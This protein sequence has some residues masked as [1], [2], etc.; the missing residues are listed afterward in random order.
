MNI[1]KPKF[2]DNENPNI[3][4]YLLLPITLLINFAN[5]LKRGKKKKKEFKIKTICIGNIYIGGTGKTSLSIKLNKLLR[6]K[7]IKSCF[8]KKYYENQ[9]DEQKLLEKNGKLFLSKN[10]VEAITQAENENYEI[11]ILDDGLQDNNINYDTRIVCFNTANWIGNGM[12]IPSGPL[13]ENISTLKEYKYVFLN[14]NINNLDNLRKFLI[15]INPNINIYLGIYEPTNLN[16][17]DTNDEYL[18]FSGIGN[19]KTFIEMIKKYKIKIKKD[20]EFP[21][22]FNYSNKDI[23]NIITQAKN[24]NCKIMTTEKDYYRLEDKNLSEIKFIKSELKLI[25]EDKVL[26]SII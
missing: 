4:A 6:E 5:L 21:D 2:W 12:T 14:G 19:H 1:K 10:R 18:V 9:K 24:L 11:A 25:D 15:N 22:H 23:N 26:K 17:F 3:F 7:N 16:E 8:V 13:R 20:I